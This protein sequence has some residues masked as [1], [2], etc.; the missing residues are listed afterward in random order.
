MPFM[1]CVHH[2]EAQVTARDYAPVASE[3]HDVHS[4]A[5]DVRQKTMTP[6]TNVYACMACLS[7]LQ[8]IL[9]FGRSGGISSLTDARSGRL[10]LLT[11]ALP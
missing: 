5:L 9:R 3:I 6:V 2:D 4:Y 10:L 7:S 11:V 8:G 1:P